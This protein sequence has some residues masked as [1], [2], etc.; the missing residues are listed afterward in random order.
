MSPTIGQV[1]EVLILTLQVTIEIETN[2]PATKPPP[3]FEATENSD[4]SN[5]QVHR[6][7]DLPASLL[8]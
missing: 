7:F 8:E 3:S 5:G 2:P 6:K 1:N 4:T